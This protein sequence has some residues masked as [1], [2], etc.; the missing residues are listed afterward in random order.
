[1]TDS[2]GNPVPNGTNVFFG[3]TGNTQGAVINSPSATNSDPPCD[4]S[5][6][7]G[8]TGVTVVNQPGVAHTCVTYPV[9][10]AGTGITIQAVAGAANDLQAFTLP[11]PPP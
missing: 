11:A 4:V 7:E 2:I 6:F 8:D 3:L 5:S 9:N 10:S 1:V